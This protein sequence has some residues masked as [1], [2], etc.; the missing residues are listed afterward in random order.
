[1]YDRQRLQPGQRLSGPALITE[2]SATTVVLDDFTVRVDDHC[3]LV[4]QR[5]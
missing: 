2:Y 3:N 5:R 4:L 1:M